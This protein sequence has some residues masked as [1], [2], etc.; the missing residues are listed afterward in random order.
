MTQIADLLGQPAWDSLVI[1]GVRLHVECSIKDQL[2][3]LVSLAAA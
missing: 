1:D 2:V 3:Q